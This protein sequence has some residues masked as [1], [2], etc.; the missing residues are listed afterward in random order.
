M[1]FL[2]IDPGTVR[3][4]IGVIEKTKTGPRYKNADVL[5]FEKN[6]RDSSAL[7]KIEMGLRTVIRRWKPD[8]I[9]VEKIYFS[10]NKKTAIAVSQARGI[11]L[12]T[13]EEFGVQIL[14]VSPNEVKVAVSGNGRATKKDVAKMVGLSLGIK[15][16]KLIDDAT[17][18][19]AIALYAYY[20][21]KF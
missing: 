21:K 10:K 19:L 9:C 8:V 3:V 18:A 14:E 4:G 2:G 17:D 13:A 1:I 12:K 20:T 5:F 6:K 15:T 7:L 16:E 11:I